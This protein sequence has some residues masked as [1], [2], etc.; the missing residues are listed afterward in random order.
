[1]EAELTV[2]DTEVAVIGQSLRR[3]AAAQTRAIVQGVTV[4]K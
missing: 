1:M 3:A 2:L 4:R